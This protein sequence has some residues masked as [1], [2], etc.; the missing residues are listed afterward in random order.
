VGFVRGFLAPFRGGFY[1]A[2][3]GLW[4]YLVIP[5]LLGL[6]LGAATLYGAHR[7]WHDELTHLLDTSPVLGW[8]FL[9]VMTLLGG[10][11]LF[12]VA[13]PLLM[14][15]FADRLCGRVEKNERG[16]S[17]E[18]PFLT[19][20]GQALVHGL[21]KLVLYA[22]ALVVGLALTAV[23]GIGSLAGV[24]L[25]ALFLAYDGFD[26]PLARRGASFG[27]K[28]AYLLRNPAQTIGFGMGATLLYLVPFAFMVAPPFA[29]VGATLAFLDVEAKS[30]NSTGKS[31]ESAAD[32][33]VGAAPA[34]ASTAT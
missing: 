31:A 28:W 15:V 16:H 32:K 6:A 3:H 4:R 34:P 23:T 8:I 19:S 20:T 5:V 29:A 7:Y 24:A 12:L 1:I 14:A 2:R 25:A 13:Q 17:P 11:V 33:A 30:G 22:I 18:M 9:A 26:Y 10:V 27:G 21:L